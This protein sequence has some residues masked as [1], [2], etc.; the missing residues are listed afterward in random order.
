MVKKVLF[1]LV[2]LSFVLISCSNDFDLFTEREVIPVVYGLLSTADTIQY[3]RI[4]RAFL[5]KNKS[6]F[7]VAGEPDSIYFDDIRVILTDPIT[8][9]EFELERVNLADKGLIRDEGFFPA[10][11]NYVYSIHSEII[12]LKGGEF[13]VLKVFKEDELLARSDAR[14]IPDLILRSPTNVQNSI[15]LQG[16]FR[17]TI[18]WDQAPGAEFYNLRF[19]IRYDERNAENGGDFEPKMVVWNIASRTDNNTIRISGDEFLEFLGNAIDE[20]PGVLRR[21]RAIDI[22]IDAGGEELANYVNVALAN[23]GITASQE[24]PIYTNIEG[25]LGVFSSINYLEAPDFILTS[26]ALDSLI[27]GRFTANLNF[28][29]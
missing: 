13:Y 10:D 5:D 4:E 8:N 16:A 2:L 22:R 29:R 24:V 17:R 20:N 3:I 27:N 15:N 12:N 7:L 23:T 6:A 1:P 18:R 19:F 9:E 25:G 28:I 26:E 21:F 11:P 14:V